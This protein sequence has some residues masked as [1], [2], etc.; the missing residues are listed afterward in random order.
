VRLPSGRCWHKRTRRTPESDPSLWAIRP[1][2]G[3]RPGE[4]HT[5]S[6]LA[7]A[8][9]A[10]GIEAVEGTLRRGEGEGGDAVRAAK[11]AEAQRR[12]ARPE[13]DIVCGGNDLNA[14][15]RPLCTHQDCAQHQGIEIWPHWVAHEHTRSAGR[16]PNREATRTDQVQGRR[17]AIYL[18]RSRHK[19]VTTASIAAWSRLSSSPHPMRVLIA[20]GP[21]GCQRRWYLQAARRRSVAAALSPCAT[22]TRSSWA[23]ILRAPT[24]ARAEEAAAAASGPAT[25]P[26]EW[27]RPGRGCRESQQ[28]GKHIRTHTSSGRSGE[29]GVSVQDR[30]AQHRI[31]SSTERR[32]AGR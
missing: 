4:C 32:A 6:S 22:A 28:G 14:G 30:H 1:Q 8:A 17:R 9:S 7:S 13:V 16:H 23:P 26:L 24:V 18:L 15:H 25:R 12:G 11:D 19:T 31:A 21:Q 10:A 20:C 27:P 29:R 3:C 2:R 5:P